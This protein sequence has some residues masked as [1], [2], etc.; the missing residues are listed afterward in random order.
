MSSSRH[1]PCGVASQEAEGP[2]R[3]FQAEDSHLLVE[4]TFEVSKDHAILCFKD[5]FMRAFCSLICEQRSGQE[6]RKGGM[7]TYICFFG[8]LG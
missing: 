2:V 7:K 3:R 6:W 4:W 8:V 5:L 1:R